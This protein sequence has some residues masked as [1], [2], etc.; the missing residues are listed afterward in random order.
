L[1]TLH[2]DR[3]N[4]EIVR[5]KTFDSLGGVLSDTKYSAWK[6]YAGIPFPSE[7]DIKRPRDHYEVVLN[8][9][10]MKINTTDVTPEKFV[11]NQPSGTEL[12]QLSQP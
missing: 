10:T 7:I 5:Q 1:R 2:F 9:V 6:E 4:L 11:L 3:H 12:Q 8:V